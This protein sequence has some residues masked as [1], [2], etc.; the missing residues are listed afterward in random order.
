[1]SVYFFDDFDPLAPPL[2]LL[3]DVELFFGDERAVGEAHQPRA[4][5][6][7]LCGKAQHHATE[8]LNDAV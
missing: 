3:S 8:A 1:M 6:S 2:A 5:T 4:E 7:Q